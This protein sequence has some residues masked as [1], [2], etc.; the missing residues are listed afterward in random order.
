MPVSKAYIEATER[1][2]QKTYDRVL[3]KVRKDAEINIDVI[4]RYAESKGVS[5]NAL[6]LGLIEEKIRNDPDFVI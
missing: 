5:V 1:Y 3:M 6:I 2:N 4:H